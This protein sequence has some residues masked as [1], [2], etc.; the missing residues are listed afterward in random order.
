MG[1][2]NDNQL[3]SKSVNASEIIGGDA[4]DLTQSRA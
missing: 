1:E 3:N 4:L 2:I